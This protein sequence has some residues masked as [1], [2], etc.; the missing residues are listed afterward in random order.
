MQHAVARGDV[1]RPTAV[2]AR[3]AIRR[4]AN[5]I[6]RLPSERRA[7][8]AVALD[9]IGGFPGRLTGPRTN[10]LIGQLKANSNYFQRHSPPA[11]KTDITDADGVVYRYFAGRCFEF[12][13][14]AEFVALN[15]RAF[16]RDRAGTKRL[17]NALVRRGVRQ[18]GGLGW[19]YYFGFGGGNAPWL[20]GMAQAMAAQGFARAANL[21]P[22]RARVYRRA[23]RQAYRP[24]P[25]R[26]TMN[27]AAGPWI[28]LYAFDSMQVLNAQLQALVSIRGYARKVGDASAARFAKRMQHAATALLPAFDTGY[29][30]LYALPG[31]VSPLLY[32]DYVVDLLKKLSPVDPSFRAAAAR[33]ASYRRQPPAFRLAESGLDEARF[34]L[35]KPATVTVHSG[36][37][38]TQRT[39]FG[40]GWH[41]LAWPGVRRGGVYPVAVTA[42][43]P[44]GNRSSFQPLPV[45]K[46]AG[47]ART[48]T[49][50]ATVSAEEERPALLVGAGLEDPGAGSKRAEARAAARADRSRLAD[51]PVEARAGAVCGVHAADR[52]GRAPRAEREAP[53]GRPRREAGAQALLRGARAAGPGPPAPDAHPCADRLLGTRVRVDA[54]GR[55]QRRA[56]R[57]CRTSLSV[58]SWQG[59]DR[60]RPPSRR[61]DARLGDRADF[62]AFRPAR[63]EKRGWTAGNVPALVKALGRSFKVVPPVLVDGL[64]MPKHAYPKAITDAACSSSVSGLI[65]DRLFHGRH[66]RAAGKRVAAAAGPAQRGT[67]LCPGLTSKAAASRIEFPQEL[68][69]SQPAAV[70]LACARDCLYLITL[71]DARG[72]PVAARR[73]ALLGARRGALTLE[74]P[75]V[76]LDRAR[77]RL[78]VRLV[79]QVNPGALTRLTSRSLRVNRS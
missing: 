57:C 72:R 45:V 25:A 6:H 68:E 58:R 50:R 17:A 26:L 7:P 62:V 60:R 48:Q 14:L 76:K 77:Y 30:T 75:R 11:P 59:R 44:A 55:S 1:D 3:A 47:R 39:F 66:A 16:A 24:I 15:A 28:R 67:I 31:R 40:A 79:D 18:L 53:A 70:V 46:V 9:Q 49:T 23:A 21:V 38:G 29:W 8:V 43:D 78:D 74:L 56:R 42:V 36:V 73:G 19:E 54:L 34:W 63:S 27:I 4:A 13:P 2:R 52:P 71:E 61:S 37:G 5:L 35:S 41:T 32:Q 65:L 51:G 20:S 12:H 10:A 69:A 22:E 33:F 64:A